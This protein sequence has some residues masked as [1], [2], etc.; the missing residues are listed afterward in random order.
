MTVGFYFRLAY[1]NVSIASSNSNFQNSTTKEFEISIVLSSFHQESE[2]LLLNKVTQ[3]SW[4]V[5]RKL[6]DDCMLWEAKLPYCRSGRLCIQSCAF[7]EF[8]R[9]S[10]VKVSKL[11]NL[12]CWCQTIPQYRGQ[13]HFQIRQRSRRPPDLFLKWYQLT[14][15][16]HWKLRQ[17]S[18]ALISSVHGTFTQDSSLLWK[19]SKARKLLRGITLLN[20]KSLFCNP[21]SDTGTTYVYK[22]IVRRLFAHIITVHTQWTPSLLWLYKCRNDRAYNWPN[23]EYTRSSNRW[24]HLQVIA[25]RKPM[26]YTERATTRTMPDSGASTSSF[27]IE[28]N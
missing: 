2:S 19:W 3:S 20:F 22:C 27:R 10:C 17:L 15:R 16:L 24:I 13:F 26:G 1:A 25:S 4:A 9:G 18:D 23:F 21:G 28:Q 8:M 12:Y 5:L 11:T 14:H 7:V 6:G